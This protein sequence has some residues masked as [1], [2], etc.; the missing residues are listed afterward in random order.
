LPDVCAYALAAASVLESARDELGRLD[1]A[2]G[3]G[4]HGVSMALAA[5]AVRKA[6]EDAPEAHGADL[7]ARL[8]TA[9]GSVGGASGPLYAAA[10]LAV[11][12]TWR[13]A[14]AEPVTVAL[15]A[16]CGEAAEAE[17]V[18]LGHARPGDKTI[19]DALD[20]AVRS[21]CETSTTSV[22]EALRQAAAA[23][24]AGAGS[25]A[26]LAARVGRASALGDRSRGHADPGAT[27]LALILE[28]I[29]NV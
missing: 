20:P 10:L 3:D 24:R 18:N 8:A 28:A 4:D 11:A 19:L 17:I 21:L 29:A 9:M 12:G 15:L 7:I 26:L 25:T 13:Q 5:R 27:S 16:R 6:L 22:K 1:S 14:D 23:A 2:A